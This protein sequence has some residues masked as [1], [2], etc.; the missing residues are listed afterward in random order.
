MSSAGGALAPNSAL[1]DK[2][3]KKR[4]P[5]SRIFPNFSKFCCQILTKF[6]GSQEDPRTDHCAKTQAKSIERI[7]CNWGSKKIFSGGPTP[8]PDVELVGDEEEVCRA[9]GG[10]Q[11]VKT[12]SK[13]SQGLARYLGSKNLWC[14]LAENPVVRFTPNLGDLKDP[15]CRAPSMVTK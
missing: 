2:I 14:H 8:K 3:R 12:F 1:R 7:L 5:K 9:W 6:G 13:N 10:Y 4:S 11:T 15:L